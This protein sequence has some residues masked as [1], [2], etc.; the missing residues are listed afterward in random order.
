MFDIRLLFYNEKR[1]YVE[2]RENDGGTRDFT[3]EH[4]AEH[5]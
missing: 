3:G 5:G 4:A 1:H 2:K